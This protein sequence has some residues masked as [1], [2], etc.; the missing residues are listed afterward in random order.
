M[1]V[2]VHQ[3]SYRYH[4]NPVLKN[5]SFSIK[6]GD[7]LVVLGPNGVGKSTLI[8]CLIGAL[9]VSPKM[10]HYNGMDLNTFHKW[11]SISYVPQRH[12]FLNFEVPMTVSELLQTATIKPLSK[13]R[14]LISLH[15]VNMCDY[16]DTNIKALS[17][18]QLQR[19]L[20]ARALIT[21]PTLL[22]LD[23]PTVGID[24]ENLQVFYQTLTLLKQQGVTVILITHDD[25][26]LTLPVTHI[27]RLGLLRHEFEE[28]KGVSKH[29]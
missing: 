12:N 2:V 9:K 8:K 13:K 11:T 21:R 14:K 6:G 7:F 25:S 20:I 19:I 10:I 23:E 18:G 16:L 28:V 17:G 15:Q 3:L 27:L 22:I 5:I 1:E 29:D 4:E 26:V 24:M